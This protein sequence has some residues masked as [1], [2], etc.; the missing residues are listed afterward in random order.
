MRRSYLCFAAI[1]VVVALSLLPVINSYAEEG[2]AQPENK[3][4]KFFKSIVK[5]PFGIAKEGT[6]TV[7][8]TAKRGLETGVSTG[9]SVVD[10]VTGKPEKIKDVIVEPVK[11]TAETAYTAVE[12]TVQTPIKGTKQAFE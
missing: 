3:V 10:T 2:S 11:G 9:T 4:A 12:G 5:W 6:E 8:R 1:L 7:G